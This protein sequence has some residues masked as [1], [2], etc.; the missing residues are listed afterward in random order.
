MKTLKIKLLPL[1][2]VAALSAFAGRGDW[3]M[4]RSYQEASTVVETPNLVFGVYDGSLLSFN[5]ADNEIKTYSVLNGLSDIYIQFVAYCQKSKSLILIYSN[6]NVD[7]FRNE[8]NIYN[9]P[10]IKD[11][12]GIEN[13]TVN[14]LEI[15]DGIA[16]IS[17]AFGIVAIDV[18]KHVCLGDYYFEKNIDIT[19]VCQKDGFLYAA[20]TDGVKKADM[21]SNLRDREN[22][23]IASDIF[24][25]N[26][27]T[28]IK[29]M[30]FFKNRFVFMEHGSVWTQTNEGQGSPNKLRGDITKISVANDKLI[31]IT[32]NSVFVYSDYDDFTELPIKAVDID[33]I[34]NKNIYWAAVSGEGISGIRQTDAAIVYQDIRIANSPKRNLA[35]N[36]YF[37]SGKLLVTGGGRGVDRSNL[38]GT[39]MVYEEDNTTGVWKWTNFDE[40]K[41]AEQ[42]GLVCR[43]FISAIVDPR[44]AN[45]YYVGSWGEGLYEFKDNEFVKLYSY[46]NSSLQVTTSM[47]NQPENI[48]RQYVRVG[49]LA[50]DGNNNL[51]AVNNVVANTVSVLSPDG[52]WQSFYCSPLSGVQ[53]DKIIID[54]RGNKWINVWRNTKISVTALDKNNELIGSAQ[55]F[56]DQLGTSVATNYYYSMQEDRSGNIWVGTDNGPIY[57]MSPD[58]VKSGLCYRKIVKDH[59]GYNKYL[60]DKEPITSIVIDGGNRKW[61]GTETSGLFVV[62]DS[63]EEIKTENF[64][65]ANSFLLSD[66]IRSLALNPETGEL[67]IGTDKGICSYMS[68]APE[69]KQTF[70]KTEVRAFPNPVRPAQNSKVTITG[71]MQDSNVKITDM[72]GNIVVEGK[73][74]GS[75]FTWNLV[76]RAGNEVKAGIYLV[77]AASS[78]GEQG[79]VTKIMVIK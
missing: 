48:R 36:M 77:F 3:K 59:N 61:F 22:W 35:F 60:L 11:K 78:S 10:Y 65:V 54:A 33:C 58:N 53:V 31:V 76:N 38:P 57:F 24:A 19:S 45:H 55:S 67:F 16:Y 74:L 27:Q 66:N 40:K 4:Y 1:F 56:T 46:D 42:T 23:K 25:G 68:G 14:N 32:S 26:T 20:T 12:T 18:E 79:I 28:S 72:A 34:N 73:S 29:K 21:T 64:T 51:Y 37:M 30:M 13:K 15:I 62:D 49:G 52:E 50:Y 7:I 70:E 63:S 17:T 47:Q 71:L 69:G 43:D 2:A 41:I 44:D 6:G 9:L 75:Q 5:P 39:L 8:N